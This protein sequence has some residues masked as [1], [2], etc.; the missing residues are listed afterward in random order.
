MKLLLMLLLVNVMLLGGCAPTAPATERTVITPTELYS[1][2]E[3]ATLELRAV[4]LADLQTIPPPAVKLAPGI[5][6]LAHGSK[7]LRIQ[8]V[9]VPFSNVQVVDG[10][11]QG[12]WGWLPST[13]VR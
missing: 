7:S 9:S 2:D 12:R 4:T 13:T 5:R 8:S 10:P 3:F 11:A 1:D 6:V